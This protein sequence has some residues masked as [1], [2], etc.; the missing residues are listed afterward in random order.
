MDESFIAERL[1]KL[2][3]LKGISARDMSLSIG[4]SPDYINKIENGRLIPSMSVFFNICDFFK[5]TPKDFFDEDNK[6][7]KLMNQIT[8]CLMEF[9][10]DTLELL[11]ELLL[12]LRK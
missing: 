2:R 10:N 6:N 5:I 11:S 3:N 7:P 1:S 4:Q 8:E 9:D 12:K